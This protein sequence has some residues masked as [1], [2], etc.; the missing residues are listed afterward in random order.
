MNSN[1][2]HFG[3]SELMACLL[4]FLARIQLG[5]FEFSLSQ[6]GPPLVTLFHL[7]LAGPLLSAVC[8][9][10]GGQHP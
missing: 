7:T 10:E 9:A 4:G 3:I 5:A 1:T 6:A 2:L 8:T